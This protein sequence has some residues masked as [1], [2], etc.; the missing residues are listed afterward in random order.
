MGR[1]SGGD[2]ER[3]HATDTLRIGGVA[4]QTSEIAER[5]ASRYGVKQF[6]GFEVA[7]QSTIADIIREATGM[8][9]PPP[10]AGARAMMARLNAARG[11]AFDMAYVRGQLD[12]HRDLLAVQERYLA[13]GR[14]PDMRHV[15]M[16]ARGQI[17]EH[18]MLLNDLR[19]GRR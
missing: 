16:L 7:E 8:T 11:A 10:D 18:L 17:K 13:E 2:A 3:R 4:L 14:D 1:G 9:P 19:T 6:A 12:G 15:A 5:R